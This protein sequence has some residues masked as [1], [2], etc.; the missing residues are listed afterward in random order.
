MKTKSAP[1]LTVV[2]FFAAASAAFAHPGHSSVDGIASGFAHPLSGWD[3]LLA[4]IAIGLWAAQLGGRACWRVPAAF[5]SVMAVLMVA[6]ASN[7]DPV[8]PAELG[9][10]VASRVKTI[11]VT[12][13]SKRSAG[14]IVPDVAT[15]VAKLKNEAKV[16]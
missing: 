10:D 4:M 14:I 5:V 2:L 15:L 1:L 11:K 13:P 7:K 16:I 3:H 12:E 8:K 6:C 9:V